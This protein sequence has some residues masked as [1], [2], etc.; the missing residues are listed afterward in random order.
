MKLLRFAAVL[1]ATLLVLTCYAKEP[2][3]S[4][5]K[6]YCVGRFLVDVPADAQIN[7]QAYEYK[8][9]RI[10]S[11]TSEESAQHFAQEMTTRQADLQSGKQK[12]KYT[13]SGIKSPAP[14]IRIF[15]LS[16]TL[17]TGPSVG[18][19]AYKWD[20]G[21][22]FSIQHTGFI[23][24][25][26]PDV[27]STLQTDLL[28]N[29]RARG[30]DDIPSRPG[31]CLENGFIA[32]DGK[33]SQYEDA[34]IS[35]KFARWPGVL[36]SVRSMTVSKLGEPTL[37]QRADGGSV[38]D[39]FKNLVNQIRTIRHGSREINGRHGEELLETVPTE[40]G[41][42]LHQF[43]WEAQGTGVSEPLKPTLIVEFE[44]GMTSVNGEPV[45]PKLTDD[46]AVAVFDAVANSIRMRPMGGSAASVDTPSPNQPLGTLARTGSICPQAGWWTCPEASSREIAGGA[47]QYLSA[48]SV[49]PVARVAG[50]PGFMGKL[51]GK[52]QWHAVNTT[53]Q[54]VAY[55]Q[56][57]EPE[58][59]SPVAPKSGPREE[60][61]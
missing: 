7:G 14:D 29:L 42:R 26:Y 55:A 28:P 27:L 61:S 2:A 53:W 4:D 10:D 12:N 3:M 45:R 9:G 22:V 24:A 48:N 36:V 43:R 33:T 34:G 54:L 20:G 40:A 25:R 19:E 35:F 56:Q 6:T 60:P 31:F 47:Y 58:S 13:L 18:I 41:Y 15:E 30:A 39:A 8:Y 38:P 46:E 23:L 32:N 16:R 51:L 59:S 44:S 50:S 57:T 21:H 5:T 11:T 49:M 37:L 52:Q 17:L 1:C